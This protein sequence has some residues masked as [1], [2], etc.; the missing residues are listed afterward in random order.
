MPEGSAA[1]ILLE[2][3]RAKSLGYLVIKENITLSQRVET[4]CVDVKE[5]G[6]F[7]EIYN[8][9]VIGYKCIVPLG[10]IVSDCIRI[11]ITDSRVKPAISFIGAYSGDQ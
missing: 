8:G 2:L 1:D 6:A 11:R 4:F 5:N 7:R 9:T 3:P 10:G